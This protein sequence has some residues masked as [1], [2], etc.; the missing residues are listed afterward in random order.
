MRIVRSTLIGTAVAVALFGRNGIVQADTPAAVSAK[1]PANAPADASAAAPANAAGTSDAGAANLEEVVV[2]GY[3]ASVEASLETKREATGVED[4]LTAEDVGKFPDK[5]V[6]EALQRLPGIVTTRDFGD[7]ER[8]NLRGTLDTLTKTTLDGHSLSTADWF[9]IDQQ[10]ATRSFNY[11]ILPADLIGK[12][13]VFK[14]A[15]ADVEEGGIGGTINI[16]TRK[17]LDL[18]PFTAYLSAEAAHT[19]LAN[20]TTPF[21]TGLISWKDDEDRFGFLVAGIYQEKKIR[22]DGNEILGYVPLSTLTP[23]APNGQLLIPTLIDAA[24]FEQD[25]IREGGNFDMQIRP[26][27]QL[28]IN[29]SGLLSVFKADNTNQSWIADPQRAIGSGGTLTNCVVSGGG[30]VAGTVTSPAGGTSNF[31]YFY[32]SFD[33]IAK[34]TSHNLD[35]NV[36]YHPTDTWSVKADFGY[37]DATGNTAPQYFPE[38]GAPGAFS[39]NLQHGVVI[40]PLANANGTTVNFANPNDFAFDFANDDVFTNDDRETYG[41]LDAEDT[42]DLGILKSIKFG[43]KFTNHERDAAGDFTTYGGFAAPI[44]AQNIPTANWSQGLSPGNFLSSFAPGGALTQFW[45]VNSAYANS[46]LAKQELIS[47]RVPYP[48]QGFSVNEKTSGAYVMGNFG[49]DHWRG[50]AGVR[51]AHTIEDTSGALSVADPNVPGAINNPFGPFIPATSSVNYNDV[52]P[53]M[54]LTYDVTQDFLVRFAAAKVMSRPDFIDMVPLVTLNPGALSGTAGNPNVNPY[55]AWQEDLSFE[56]YPDRSTAYTA[57]FYYKDLKSFIV[58]QSSTEIFPVQ[59]Q[60]IP[61]SSC[62]TVSANQFNCPFTVDNK[63][64]S[65]GGT[66][67]GIEL[68]VTRSIWGGFGAQ[69]NFSYSDATLRDG[70]PFPGNSRHTYNFTAFYENR[71]LSARISWTQRSAFFVQFDRTSELDE[72]ALTSLDTAWSLNLTDYMAVTFEAQNLTDAKVVQYDNTLALPRAI[73]DNGRVYF[74]G[75]RLRF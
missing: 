38:F 31:A 22:R 42:L 21:A 49:G 11:L 19:D 63:V 35:L 75:V 14:T 57:A 16:E 58:D 48:I 3:R 26:T 24:L 65:N 45:M 33:R 27:D 73:Y 74:A 72:G 30:C 46:V 61:S 20:K 4:V 44:I 55:R 70:E 59:N 36:K 6:A 15:S 7:G 71:L 64:N 53:S 40:K 51:F 18:K 37:T 60:T 47:G 50:N 25:R 29:F 2:Q 5:D 43:A 13:E 10:N 66:L 8:I 1:A 68:S 39:Y 54:N 52:L 34:A 17:P 12:A 69:G 62:T 67:K 28:D 23:T 56:Y 41:Y 9:I 32:D